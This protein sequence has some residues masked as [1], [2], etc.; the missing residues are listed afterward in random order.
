MRGKYA[1]DQMN[2]VKARPHNR[3]FMKYEIDY[4]RYLKAKLCKI[5]T[6]IFHRYD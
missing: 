4:Q 2:F 3:D 6:F 1:V 5:S